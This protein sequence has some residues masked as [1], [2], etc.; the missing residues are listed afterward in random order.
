MSAVPSIREV[1]EATLPAGESTEVIVAALI[2]R[3]Q[4][5]ADALRELAVAFGLHAEIVAQIL[6]IDVPMGEPTTVEQK[7]YVHQQY[8]NLVRRLQSGQ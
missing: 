4:S 8:V 7:A 3:E 1:V 5:M 6:A 2:E